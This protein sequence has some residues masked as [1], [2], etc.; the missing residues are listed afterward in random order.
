MAWLLE[1][2][3]RRKL[4]GQYDNYVA[5]GDAHAQPSRPSFRPRAFGARA[6]AASAALNRKAISAVIPAERRQVR[7]PGSTYPCRAHFPVTGVLGSRVSPLARLA[8]DD[9]SAP[10]Q[11]VAGTARVGLGHEVD[12]PQ[13]AV[14]DVLERHRHDAARPVD[15]HMAEELQ[16]EARCQVLALLGAAAEGKHRA[17]AEGVV[18]PPRAPGAGVQRAGDEFPERVK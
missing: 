13:V 3:S 15:R 4:W 7:E 5:V 16:A 9:S 6:R 2:D 10:D 14:G 11:H 17:R 18:E 12:R 1:L 8:R